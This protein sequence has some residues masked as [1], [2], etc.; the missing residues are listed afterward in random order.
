MLESDTDYIKMCY[1]S[2]ATGNE[3][4]RHD[5]DRWAT[6]VSDPDFGSGDRFMLLAS[7]CC[8]SMKF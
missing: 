7:H 8:S 6:L 4:T 2:I 3:R 5:L 1:L